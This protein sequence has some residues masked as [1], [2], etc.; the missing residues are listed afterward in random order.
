MTT[1]QRDPW[2]LETGLPNDFDFWVARARFGYNPNY[3]SGSALLLIWEG[4]SPDLD[5]EYPVIW[6]VGKGWESREDGVSAFHPKRQGFISTSMYGRL[7]DRV[8][9][10]LK[11]DMRSRGDP[12]KATIWEGLGFHLVTETLTFG[13]GIL[14]DSGGSTDH[15]MP[16]AFLG[17]RSGLQVPVRISTTA[18]ETATA[19][20]GP[21][22]PTASAPPASNLNQQLLIWAKT[23]DR[24]A[25]QQKA[26]SVNEVV[27]D[28]A[29]AGLLTQILDD[30]ANG[31]WAKARA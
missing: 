28:P 7:I 9:N 15:L 8:L 2:A 29:N 25:F 4:E 5:I 21:S 23:M 16:T 31:F 13:K 18:P 3:Q 19:P 20:A 26:L 6:P 14:E 22:V 11:V 1:K 17:T 27:N 12:K 30:S 10:G 24:P